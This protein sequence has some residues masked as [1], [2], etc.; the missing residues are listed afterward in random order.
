MSRALLGPLLGLALALAAP[1]LPAAARPRIT[2]TPSSVILGQTTAVTI[3]VAGLAGAAAPMADVNVGSVERIETAGSVVRIHYLPPESNAPQVL[4]L[5]VWR[6]GGL[7]APVYF[8]RVPMLGRTQVPV[9]TRPNSTVKV[10][11]ADR[12]FGPVD[13][14]PRGRVRVSVQVPPGVTRA[15]V[16]VTDRSNLTSRK[17]IRIKQPAYNELMLAI[18]PLS[19]GSSVPRFRVTVGLAGRHGGDG[20]PRVQVGPRR[21]ELRQRRAGGWSGLWAPPRRPPEGEIPVRVWLPGRPRSVR[22]ARVGISPAA[23]SVNII[24]VSARASHRVASRLHGE[25]GVLVG[26]VHNLGEVVSP[27][28]A[29]DLG[30]DYPLGPGRLGLR[31]FAGFSW[32]SQRIEAVGGLQPGASSVALIP[33]GGGL[34]YRLPLRHLT[35]YVFAGCLAQIV[36]TSNSAEYTQ[37]SLRH[38]VA[39]GAI[40]L[41]GADRQLG[42][43]RVLVQAGYQWSR[44]E[45]LE[46]ELQAGGVILEG[47][48]RLDL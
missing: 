46:V 25:L 22:L 8:F 12:V 3:E 42:P 6:A 10:M 33:I 2:I 44:I 1:A 9:R 45:N 34:T 40:G 48:Y 17:Q 35:P 11:V 5:A 7:E 19:S 37:E 23:L 39:P 32:A 30:L 26:M 36:R 4:G 14:G 24:R 43:G 15:E 41:L 27:R 13:S 38:D 29:V 20:A 16:E 18:H 47:G 28:F 31:L 21:L